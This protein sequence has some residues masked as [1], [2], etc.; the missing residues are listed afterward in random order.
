MSQY[1][2]QLHDDAIALHVI[3]HKINVGTAAVKMRRDLLSQYVKEVSGEQSHI[4]M[5]CAAAGISCEKVVDVINAIGEPVLIYS[6]DPEDPRR[7]VTILR[8]CELY[9]IRAD[10]DD[11]EDNSTVT[12]KPVD[13]PPLADPIVTTETIQDMEES[14]ETSD[15]HITDEMTHLPIKTAYRPLFKLALPDDTT[16]DYRRV[17]DTHSYTSIRLP[18]GPVTPKASEIGSPASQ[19][20]ETSSTIS[21]K[22][23]KRSLQLMMKSLGHDTFSQLVSEIMSNQSSH[24]NALV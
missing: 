5:I 6:D 15:I 20:K 16:V 3:S 11:D 17:T 24:A 4:S 2:S 12:I 23:A 7:Y 19:E 9:P 13:M 8:A 21:V 1:I 14:H 10:D 22:Y 18:S